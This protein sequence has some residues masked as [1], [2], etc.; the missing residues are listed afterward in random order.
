MVTGGIVHTDWLNENRNRK[1]PFFDGASMIDDSGSITLPNELIVDLTFPVHAF[2]YDVNQFY[3]Y[4]VT[5]FG[6]GVTITIGYSGTAI[7][8]RSITESEHSD[9]DTYYIEGTGD[10][11]DSVGR[12][13]IGRI[14]DIKNYG[15]QYTFSAANARLLPT[16]IRPAIQGVSGL[17]VVS[18]ENDISELIQGDVDLISGENISMVVSTGSGGVKEVKIS[19]VN[20]PNYE[21]DCGCPDDITGDPIKTINGVGPNNAGAFFLEGVGCV[22]LDNGIVS[23]GIQINDTCA[24]PCCGCAELDKIRSE[25]DRLATQIATQKAFAQRALANIEQMR[26]SILASKFGPVT[27]C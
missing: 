15:G 26:T 20:N 8:T 7:A 25:V 10:F 19:A 1:Y 14:Q 18:A 2:D 24:E 11:A 16:V 3:L 22:A 13:T 27:P 6:G 23:N 12:I 5:V 4:S 9:N 21:E 17:R